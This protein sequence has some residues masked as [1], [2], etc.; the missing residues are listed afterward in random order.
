MSY[1]GG[2]GVQDIEMHPSLRI[3]IDCFDSAPF[4][5][6][7]PRKGGI[8]NQDPVLIRDFRIIRRFELQWKENQAKLEQQDSAEA[9]ME[10]GGFGL[11]HALDEFIKSQEEEDYYE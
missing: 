7:F 5:K 3:Y 9:S 6:M 11:E 1:F 4:P 2:G 8:W 10:G